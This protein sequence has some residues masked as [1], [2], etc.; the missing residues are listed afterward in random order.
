MFNSQF[1]LK[2]TNEILNVYKVFF[3]K[4][5]PQFFAALSYEEVLHMIQDDSTLC[6]DDILSITLTETKIH[7]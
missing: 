2:M 1:Q 3:T 7:V 5:N 6:K 4:T